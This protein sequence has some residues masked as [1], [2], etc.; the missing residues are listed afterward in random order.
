MITSPKC[1]RGVV[2]DRVWAEPAIVASYGRW[3][4]STDS[5][6]DLSGNCGI[7]KCVD[8]RKFLVWH[9]RKE[10]KGN[11]RRAWD[12]GMDLIVAAR[13]QSGGD[14]N[15]QHAYCSIV[16][17][18]NNLHVVRSSPTIAIHLPKPRRSFK[19]RVGC[20]FVPLGRPQRVVRADFGAAARQGCPARRAV[21]RFA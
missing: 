9:R 18:T 7:G 2:A 12:R 6:T 13:Q 3:E 1:S 16:G 5:T 19:R 15:P 20:R 8:L 21:C 17:A 4:S 10:G 11:W 14:Q